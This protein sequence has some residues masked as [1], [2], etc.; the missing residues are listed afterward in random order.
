M[1]FEGWNLIWSSKDHSR[2]VSFKFLINWLQLI[3][4]RKFPLDLFH[5]TS[6]N[7][8]LFCI[9][10][11]CKKYI[12][13]FANKY[14]VFDFIWFLAFSSRLATI[15]FVLQFKTIHKCRYTRFIN[16]TS[17]PCRV[18]SIKSKKCEDKTW[19]Q[20]FA[21]CVDKNKIYKKN[22]TVAKENNLRIEKSLIR[23][24]QSNYHHHQ[25]GTMTKYKFI[26][27]LAYAWR[28]K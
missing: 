23:V 6:W 28:R 5:M 11:S 22:C 7:T 15:S 27:P 14:K 25:G 3:K 4:K 21:K 12:F 18:T 10:T 19:G 13:L 17:L 20:I 24:M 8:L 16:R 1:I 9:C 26:G 2:C